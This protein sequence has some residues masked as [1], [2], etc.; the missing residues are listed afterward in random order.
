MESASHLLATDD[1]SGGGLA[2][3]S[4]RRLRRDVRCAVRDVARK[5][6][7]EH[8]IRPSS[9]TPSSGASDPRI[10]HPPLPPVAPSLPPRSRLPPPSSLCFARARGATSRSRNGESR[11]PRDLPATVLAGF[12]AHARQ[13]SFSLSLTRACERTSSPAAPLEVS[14]CIITYLSR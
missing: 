7:R 5:C 4:R 13:A 10:R 12:S 8:S 2:T 3:V 1:D 14:R 9:S 6:L 11:A